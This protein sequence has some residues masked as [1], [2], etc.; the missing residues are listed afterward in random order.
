MCE[1]KLMTIQMNNVG[2]KL[3]FNNCFAVSS[4]EKSGGLAILW[5][6]STR[7]NI[8]SFSN[9]HIDAEVDTKNEKQIRSTGGL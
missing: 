6:S 3:N 7:V 4:N 9:H 2:K 8:T 1:T 5:N